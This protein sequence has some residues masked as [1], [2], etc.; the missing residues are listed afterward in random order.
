MT[1]IIS[2]EENFAEITHIFQLLSLIVHNI[3][4]NTGDYYIP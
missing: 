4:Q 2:E 3:F 1:R